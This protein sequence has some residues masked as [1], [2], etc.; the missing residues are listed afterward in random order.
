MTVNVL[1]GTHYDLRGH[2]V[3]ERALSLVQRIEKTK[4]QVSNNFIF[5]LPSSSKL[6][7]IEARN[8]KDFSIA[9][10]ID[11]IEFSSYRE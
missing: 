3:L 7:A 10:H 11:P 4:H 2:M 6:T 9:C 8:D 1:I 5:Y